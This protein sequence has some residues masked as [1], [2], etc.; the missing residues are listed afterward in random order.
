MKYYT[1]CIRYIHPTEFMAKLNKTAIATLVYFTLSP[2]TFFRLLLPRSCRRD[3]CSPLTTYL[4]LH[5]AIFVRWMNIY[6]KSCLA[7]VTIF[8]LRS[9]NLHFH[10][11]T[12]AH[13]THW[14]G[15]WSLHSIWVFV[16]RENVVWRC[17]VEAR[18]HTHF[19]YKLSRSII[20][21]VDPQHRDGNHP[22]QMAFLRYF[23]LQSLPP[24]PN[25]HIRTHRQ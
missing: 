22:T 25:R 13:V 3:F 5:T 18:T 7:I 23:D 11:Y 9:G 15:S 20:S 16:Q 17:G 24:K 1:N 8:I 10:K 21:S 6:G 12:R 4:H 2:E 19:R 14:V